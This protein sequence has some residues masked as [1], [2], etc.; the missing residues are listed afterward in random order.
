MS[1]H[2][3]TA[4]RGFTLIE[5]VVA[6]G[7]LSIFII[8]FTGIFNSFVTNQRRDTSRQLVLEQLRLAMEVVN[9]E[10]RTAY[11]STFS[12]TDGEGHGLMFRNQNGLCVHYRLRDGALERA[13]AEI[14]SSNCP[15]SN[16]PSAAYAT[17]VSEDVTI[18]Y[19]RFDPVR[20]EVGGGG[21]DGFPQA[22]LLNQGFVTL[23]IEASDKSETLAP[24]K[25][26]STVTS[27]Q[28]IPYVR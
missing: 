9:R 22:T 23:I 2:K 5:M 6:A 1:A 28:V 10:L 20:A 11:G 13:E 14:N 21:V 12:L 8:V 18:P 25:L 15:S 16:F 26:Q 24:V 3:P 7:L 4:N 17:L 19:L 27:R